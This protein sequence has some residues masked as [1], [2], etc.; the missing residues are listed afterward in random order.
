[1]K[2]CSYNVQVKNYQLPDGSVAKSLQWYLHQVPGARSYAYSAAGNVG[3]AVFNAD[4]TAEAVI[5]ESPDERFVPATLLLYRFSP[6][7]PPA[8]RANIATASGC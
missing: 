7:V 6:A 4:G 3:N 8:S 1:M 2:Y 5:Q